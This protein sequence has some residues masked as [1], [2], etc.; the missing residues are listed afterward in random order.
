VLSAVGWATT[1]RFAAQLAN[2]AMTLITVGLLSPQDYGLMAITM[3]VAGFLASMSSTGFA[4]V[5]V[6]NH[7]IS[8]DELRAVFGVLLVINAACLALL[9]ALAPLAAWFYG[10]PR[11]VALLL[12][13]S[14]MFVAIALQAIPRATL[15]KKLDLKTA[16]RIDLVSNIT[17]G[18]L[19]LLL[20]WNWNKAGVWSL[21][22]GM[23]FTTFLKA[24]GLGLAAPYFRRPLFAHRNL[25]E[26]LRFG[27]LRSLESVLWAIYSSSDVFIIG[28][29]LGADILG[30]YSVSHMSRQCRSRSLCWSS[31]RLLFR[32]LPRSSTIAPKPY[33]T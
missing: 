29:L 2:W 3:A 8:E 23:L 24:I 7:R 19:T 30:V 26:I 13:A 33:N 14:L 12:V 6:Q 5:I 9:C 25:S 28:K 15:E 1:T 4:N 27:G 10:E 11:L 22:V 20:A 18:A 32:L 17:G 21:V 16:S 31:V